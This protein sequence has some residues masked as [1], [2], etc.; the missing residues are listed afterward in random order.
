MGRG[1]R[2]QAPGQPPTPPTPSSQ[3]GASAQA[4]QPP[5]L[6]RLQVQ[7]ALNPESLATLGRRAGEASSLLEALEKSSL[8]G[9]IPGGQLWAFKAMPGPSPWPMDATDLGAVRSFDK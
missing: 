8:R 4:L 3:P 6:L 5:Y 9:W 1:T 7:T 2:A